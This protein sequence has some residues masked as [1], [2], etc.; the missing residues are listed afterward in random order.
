MSTSILK[1]YLNQHLPMSS[2]K[3]QKALKQTTELV[4]GDYLE[5]LA[6][7]PRNL[8]YKY[9]YDQPQHQFSAVVREKCINEV[10]QEYVNWKSLKAA[11]YASV[12][13]LAS[14]AMERIKEALRMKNEEKADVSSEELEIKELQKELKTKVKALD[15]EGIKW[16]TNRGD[17]LYKRFAADHEKVVQ[18]LCS[19]ETPDS[20]IQHLRYMA[21]LRVQ[22]E[23]GNIHEHEAHAMVQDYL[24]DKFKTNQTLED[25]QKSLA[26]N[27]D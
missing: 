19:H 6:E 2:K 21:Y 17:G 4:T 20:H 22:I 13:E 14:Q 5:Q 16:V 1:D 12:D 18:T 7:D 3:P 23:A 26:T 9:E 8:V 10:R 24:V 25:Y 15:Q 27:K 11:E